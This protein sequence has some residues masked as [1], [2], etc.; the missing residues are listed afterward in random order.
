M[1]DFSE[2]GDVFPSLR[3]MTLEYQQKKPTPQLDIGFAFPALTSLTIDCRQGRGISRL[4]GLQVCFL[5]L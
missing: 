4:A 1:P 3:K 5:T 2:F